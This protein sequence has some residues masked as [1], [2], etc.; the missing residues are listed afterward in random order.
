MDTPTAIFLVLVGSLITYV[1]TADNADRVTK[2]KCQAAYVSGMV[3]ERYNGNVPPAIEYK[4]IRTFG[5]GT[6]EYLE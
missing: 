4:Y 5:K 6:R 2:E 1:I 3:I